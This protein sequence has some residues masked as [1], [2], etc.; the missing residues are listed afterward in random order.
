MNKLIALLTLLI[1]TSL[2]AEQY[3]GDF[4]PASSLIGKYTLESGNKKFCGDELWVFISEK[5]LDLYEI[6][7]DPEFALD[8][9]H[10]SFTYE[11]GAVTFHR[12]PAI[13]DLTGK[14]KKLPK[15]TLNIGASVFMYIAYTKEA[16]SGLWNEDEQTLTLDSKMTYKVGLRQSLPV[17]HKTVGHKN[18]YAVFKKTGDQLI[19]DLKYEKQIDSYI[20]GQ[21]DEASEERC[22]FNLKD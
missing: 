13:Y 14:T 9:M 5:D 21:S 12:G 10:F 1:S 11:T 2:F 18:F 7:R 8:S 22:T 4:A 6:T 15:K 17:F 3:V 16:V 19:M 20:L